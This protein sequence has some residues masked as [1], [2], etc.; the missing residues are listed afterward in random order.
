MEEKKRKN[1]KIKT[2]HYGWPVDATEFVAKPLMR[3]IYGE[4]Q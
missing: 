2:M 1:N 3:C 4:A